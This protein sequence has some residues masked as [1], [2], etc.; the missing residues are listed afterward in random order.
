MKNH[1]LYPKKGN[2]QDIIMTPDVCMRF[3]VWSYFYHDI[4]PER[5][6]SYKSYGK[7]SDKDVKNLDELKEMLFKCYEEASVERA[8][9]QFQM[10]K[11]LHEPCPYPQTELDNLFA[12][13][14]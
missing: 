12:H 10:A 4:R 1:Y 3:L 9:D 6:I 13:E 5:G 11:V 8:C 2:M 7:F 14:K